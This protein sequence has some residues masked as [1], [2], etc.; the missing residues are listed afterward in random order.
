M[1]ASDF[2][3]QDMGAHP[4]TLDT[5]SLCGDQEHPPPVAAA[6]G[7]AFGFVKRKFITTTLLLSLSLDQVGW[8]TNQ[9]PAI[10][11]FQ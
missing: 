7:F 6:F 10:F 5:M 2:V 3:F 4:L 11:S 9:N 1:P 8:S